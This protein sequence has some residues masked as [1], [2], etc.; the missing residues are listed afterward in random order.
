MPSEEPLRSSTPPRTLHP[1]RQPVPGS[2]CR[3]RTSPASR[4]AQW[5]CSHNGPT[6]NRRCPKYPDFMYRE[7]PDHSR[8]LIAAVD[9][10]ARRMSPAW[11]PENTKR[12]W[13]WRKA[14]ERYHRHLAPYPRL[15]AG[16][17]GRRWC[18]CP[19]RSR[20]SGGCRSS[21]PSTCVH[22]R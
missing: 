13:V 15:C 10:T 17:P 14:Y 11:T 5:A 6:M 12:R 2:A 4:A 20:C 9:R 19:R 18:L 16:A 3:D 1:P 22:Q 21:P 7:W 8:E